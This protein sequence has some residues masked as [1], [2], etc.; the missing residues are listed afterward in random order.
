MKYLLLYIML[1]FYCWCGLLWPLP[2]KYIQYNQILFIHSNRFV[3]KITGFQ[4]DILTQAIHRYNLLIFYHNYSSTI[5]NE[6]I[7]GS[8]LEMLEI[9]V[10]SPDEN[11]DSKTNEEYLLSIKEGTG[12]LIA[13]TVFG[14][15]RG[16]ETF[17]QLV[18]F[19]SNNIY[20]INKCSINDFPRFQYRGFLIDS[21]RHF[22]SLSSIYQQIDAMAY[23]KM[24]V[25]HWHIVDD[26][27]FPYSSKI[28]PLL[29]EKGSYNPSHRYSFQDIESI[30][31][32]AKY[33][34]IRVI[35]EF[36]T[37]GHTASWGLGYPD[38]LTTCYD[39]NQ[40]PSGKGPFNIISNYTYNFLSNF[41]Q[42]VS[43]VFPDPYIH[44]GGD[45][46]PFDCWKS[47]P[48]IQK[49]MKSH[50]FTNYNQ[51][52]QYYEIK[53]LDI[54]SSYQKEYIIWE[55]VFDNNVTV[56]PDTI[57]D[58]WRGNWNK[59]ISK[60]TKKGFKTILSSCWYLNYIS[61]GPDWKNYYRCDPQEFE[62]D[63]EQK[64]L[65][66]GGHACMW[67]EYVDSTNLIS[68][69]W[70]RGCAVAER[71]WSSKYV[72]DIDDA[73]KRIQ[74]Q[75]CRMVRRNIPA[76]PINGPSYCVPEFKYVY[77]KPY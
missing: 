47:N 13:I 54:I 74:E 48:E 7:N 75:Q 46:V 45:E 51:A 25:L 32:F 58:V 63:E 23:N 42:E 49:W 41:F 27:S 1:P 68:R 62:G 73:E 21:S 17:S 3:F 43:Q 70:P 57:I 36:D 29:S 33:R 55:D 69:N 72:K 14:A 28:F 26:Q 11:L 77:N 16:L 2:Q 31:K 35:P 56:K 66:I 64:K 59:T 38:L 44:A 30:I 5:E 19:Y 52:E 53:L 37:P 40:K 34:G 67:G 18:D 60:V 10:I 71:L 76:E 12:Q 24:N 9:N 22:L 20:T 65:V 15:L 8:T 6:K 61:Y 4:N 39:N 50:G